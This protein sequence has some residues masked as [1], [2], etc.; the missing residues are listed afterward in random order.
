MEYPRLY[1][2]G[3]FLNYDSDSNSSS[4][5]S[6]EDSDSDRSDAAVYET[7]FAEVPI[8]ETEIEMGPLFINEN[9]SLFIDKEN[10]ESLFEYS[11]DEN[12]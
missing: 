12:Q 4:G 1:K 7:E 8:N 5:S 3:N 10:S 2:V 9:D 11:D 6:N